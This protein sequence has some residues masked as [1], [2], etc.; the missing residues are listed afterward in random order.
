MLLT[1]IE[2]IVEKG[3]ANNNLKS[4]G[5][6]VICLSAFQNSVND[7]LKRV[8]EQLLQH[9]YQQLKQ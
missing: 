6:F 1:I 9:C 3:L 2:V 7:E 4:S 8:P 5:M